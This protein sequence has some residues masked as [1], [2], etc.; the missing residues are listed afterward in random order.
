MVDA[1]RTVH[2]AHGTVPEA[3]VA[4]A[5]R[6]SCEGAAAAFGAVMAAAPLLCTLPRLWDCGVWAVG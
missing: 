5:V 4:P 6:D 2:R 1:V 3:V